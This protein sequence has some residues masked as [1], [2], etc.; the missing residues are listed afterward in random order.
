[1]KR[2]N[3]L[4]IQTIAEVGVNHNGK[5]SYAKK[6]IDAA[7][8]CGAT[9]VKFQIYETSA[10][11]TEYAKKTEYQKKN[12]GKKGSQFQ[13][14]KKYEFS[15]EQFQILKNYCKKR[16]IKFLASAFDLE[17]LKK[18]RKLKLNTYKIPSG[19][20][21]NI[22]YLELLAS[23][24]KNVIL[25]TG[26]ASI[27]EIQASIKVLTKNGLKKKQIILM[28]CTS[29]YPTKMDQVNLNVLQYYKK[30]FKLKLGFS[31]HT[32][33]IETPLFAIFNGARIIEKHITLNKNMKGPDHKASLD[34][35]EF[36][37]MIK[38][39]DN[40]KLSLRKT[41]KNPNNEEIKNSILVRKSIVAKKNI[42]KGEVY[43]QNNITCKRPG[44]GILPSKFNGLLNKKSNRNYQKD[45][46]ITS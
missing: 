9:F 14:L 11:T 7:K 18:M 5:L 24:K 34:V 21:T 17:S 6:L 20:I 1:M 12:E 13:M 39:I 10:L 4:N 25:S 43:S 16:N 2:I 31:D 28:Q 30:K 23:F 40:F 32:A 35:K 8:D 45:D 19:E 15:F 29:N 36:A 22:P 37:K 42:K 26:M 27:K 41:K 44:T 46:L 33:E 38:N 3:R